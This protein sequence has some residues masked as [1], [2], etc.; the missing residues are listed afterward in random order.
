MSGTNNNEVASSLREACLLAGVRGDSTFLVDAA[1]LCETA[2]SFHSACEWIVT[3]S[4]A[5][6]PGTGEDAYTFAASFYFDASYST[7]EYGVVRLPG[8]FAYLKCLANSVQNNPNWFAIAGV[9][10][11]VVSEIARVHHAAS[12]LD[13][14]EFQPRDGV[15]VNCVPYITPYGYVIWG[16]RTLKD[17]KRMGDLTALS[18]LN[19]RQMTNDIKRV[20]YLAC[21]SLMFEQNSDVLWIAFKARVTPTLDNMKTSS[22]VRDYTITRL[23]SDRKGGVKARITLVPI[24]PVEDWDITVELTDSL[25]AVAG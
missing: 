6:V 2:S 13:A 24:E 22:G 8:S 16:T 21:K 20:T 19:V 3:G 1:P 17:N 7:A 10:R 5:T 12:S 11:G 23:A 25:T 4:G 14:D 9:S 18:F 15:A